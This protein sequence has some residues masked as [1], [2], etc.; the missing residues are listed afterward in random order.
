MFIKCRRLVALLVVFLQ[1]SLI[2]CDGGEISTLLGKYGEMKP[3]ESSNDMDDEVIAE[4]YLN[5]LLQNL[6][7]N[8]ESHNH[9]CSFLCAVLT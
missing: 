5:D 7:D 4:L 8:G 6:N 1:I 3:S 2:S 9:S